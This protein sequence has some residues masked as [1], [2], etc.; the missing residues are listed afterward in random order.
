MSF[1]LIKMPIMQVEAFFAM[2]TIL[3]ATHMMFMFMTFFLMELSQLKKYM[4]SGMLPSSLH[5]AQL[6]LVRHLRNLIMQKP[7]V[8]LVDDLPAVHNSAKHDFSFYQP[9]WM[10]DGYLASPGIKYIRPL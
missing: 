8:Q 9:I 10:L 7:V 2:E 1:E 3:T 4:Y 6:V 5:Q